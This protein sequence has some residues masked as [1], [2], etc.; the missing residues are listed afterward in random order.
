M[1][2]VDTYVAGEDK[3]ESTEVQRLCDGVSDLEGA[4]VVGGRAGADC[5]W[6]ER[7]I[8]A[9]VKD[10]ESEYSIGP[11]GAYNWEPRKRPW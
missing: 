2:P 4:V 1:P 8:Q 11:D 3:D 9:G 6:G 5:F 7:T 10:P